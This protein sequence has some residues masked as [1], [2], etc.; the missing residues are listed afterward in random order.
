MRSRESGTKKRAAECAALANKKT[1]CLDIQK[2]PWVRLILC[3]KET[4]FKD[5]FFW[6]E[7]YFISRGMFQKEACF[8]LLRT[9]F[10]HQ[11]PTC[12]NG[13]SCQIKKQESEL[14]NEGYRYLGDMKALLY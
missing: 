1:S 6:S 4:F 2:K 14:L 7:N 3:A 13:I 9:V 12:A 5:L 11:Q 8:N 10:V